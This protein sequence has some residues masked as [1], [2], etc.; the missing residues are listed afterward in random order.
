MFPMPRV[1]HAMA[2]DGLLFK[3]LSRIHS[4]RK[5]PMVATIVSGF[6]AGKAPRIQPCGG[7]EGCSEN[8]LM[9]HVLIA[10]VFAFLLDLKDLV[11]LMSIGTLL[12]YSLVAMCVLILRCVSSLC[13]LMPR[14]DVPYIVMGVCR[15]SFFPGACSLGKCPAPKMEAADQSL[16]VSVGI[17]LEWLL[18]GHC[19]SSR[20]MKLLPT[21]PLG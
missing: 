4:G 5:T 9:P 14:V 8:M 7:L 16:C 18:W 21:V 6:I 3:F 2:E 1:I 20:D 11:D 15:H 10:A 19:W 13:V 12:A 17:S